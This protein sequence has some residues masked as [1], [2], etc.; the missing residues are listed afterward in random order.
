MSGFFGFGSGCAPINTFTYVRV[1]ATKRKLKLENVECM[2]SKE[3]Y[4]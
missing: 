4:N 2:K 1:Y 3:N